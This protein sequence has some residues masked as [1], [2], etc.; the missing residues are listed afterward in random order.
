MK[1][2]ETISKH[3]F[4][5]KGANAEKFVHELAVKSFLLDW[6]FPNAKFTNGKE[7]CDLLVVFDETAIIWQI[8]DLKLDQHGQYREAEVKKNLRQLAGARR[9]L[10]DL[11]TPITLTNPRRRPEPFDPACIKRVFLISA[12]MG[13]G[14]DFFCPVE[15]DK[16]HMIH[17]FTR[18]FVEIALRELDTISDFMTYLGRKEEFLAREQ[19]FIISGGE[20]ELLATYLM[21]N[22]S[23]EQLEGADFI[24]LEGGSWENLQNQPKYQ[25]KKRADQISYGWDSIIN[26]AHEGSSRYEL[27]ARELARPNRL[28]RRLLSKVFSEAHMRAH[29]DTAHDLY[30]RILPTNGTTYCFLF[31]DDPEPR[32]TRKYMLKAICLVARG[33]FQQ[34]K[35]VIG[36]ATEKK[37]RPI[38][39]YDFCLTDIPSWSEDC[40]SRMEELQRRL[41]LFLN[42]EVGY[43][44]EDE[45][46]SSPR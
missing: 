1:T 29:D 14:E 21:N 19:S 11:R 34:N 35:K 16:Q 36:I 5:L 43:A 7:I 10:L 39:T 40:Q 4:D 15:E 17:V 25:A 8:K 28:D 46:P 20:E 23:F 38:C 22:R 9:R 44:R 42:P 13:E 26:R 31:L 18:D 30:R 32:E 41:G 24:H 33:L 6:C 3:Y 27:V 12:L 37:L 45:Y 2:P